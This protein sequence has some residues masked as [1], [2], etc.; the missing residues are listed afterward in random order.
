MKSGYKK[1]GWG[2][3]RG[4]KR[5]FPIKPVTSYL[6]FIFICDDVLMPCP[7]PWKKSWDILHIISFMVLGYKKN[8][9]LNFN[10]W[11]WYKSRRSEDRA[12]LRLER[13]RTAWPTPS[14]PRGPPSR[15]A[16]FPAEELHSSG[17]SVGRCF[18]CLYNI[19]EY[20]LFFVL[21]FICMHL[22]GVRY[23]RTIF[24]FIQI[25]LNEIN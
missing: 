16:L 8:I 7:I 10:V 25:Q 9:F 5:L 6:C 22:I 3:G 21:I 19:Y 14:T 11:L 23:P 12:R 15:R 24:H 20:I 13:R 4:V 17:L 18:P 2:G 1:R